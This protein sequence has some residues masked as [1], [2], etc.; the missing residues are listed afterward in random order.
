MHY[1]HRRSLLGIAATAAILLTGVGLGA[2][3]PAI[4]T[5]GEEAPA[6]ASAEPLAA[7]AQVNSTTTM[8]PV[9]VPGQFGSPF[10]ATATVELD[11]PSNLSGQIV[12]LW[13][14]GELAVS[15]PLLYIGSGK[16][17]GVLITQ[18]TP[19]AGDYK[20]VVKFPG[21]ASSD[22][23]MAG[24]LSSESAPFEFTVAPRPSTTTVT[25]AP[26]AEN[27]FAPIDV[28]ASVSAP[29]F[30][31]TGSAALMVDDLE[32]ATAPLQ[33]SPQPFADSPVEF[34]GVRL[35][36]TGGTLWVKYL[37]SDD[38][39]F[40]PSASAR[41]AIVIHPIDTSVDVAL[42][43]AQ[44]RADATS[45]LE[46]TVT[47]ETLRSSQDPVGGV[48]V[49]V[50]GDVIVTMAQAQDEDPRA[51]NGVARFSIPLAGAELGLGTHDIIVNFLPEPGFKASSSETAPLTVVG[52]PTVLTTV[53]S[54]VTGTPAHPPVVSVQATVGAGNDAA[55][56]ANAAGLQAPVQ[57]DSP[58]SNAAVAG[59][60][61]AFV[62]TESLG[63]AVPLVDGTAD[64]QLAGL[65]VGSHEVELQ[66]TP[67]GDSNALGASTSVTAVVSAD[68]TPAPQPVTP[69]HTTK[70]ALAKT[71]AADGQASLLLG[72]AAALIIG[73]GIAFSAPLRRG[74]QR[75]V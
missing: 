24:A 41:G 58:A 38:G 46:I 21:F 8:N 9:L 10:L 13:L 68:A 29:G 3:S 17:S 67:V 69:E 66:F 18:N 74:R 62:G 53:A 32:I 30:A 31:I 26:T 39:N 51:G 71:G 19:S 36:G 55:A 64:V 70:S 44:V 56:P 73:A 33:A 25:S 27:A 1:S 45:S 40:A 7:P 63:D 4:A 75:Q 57:A 50:D 5:S 23:G 12:E 54:T 52:I 28:S 49:L 47:N 20:A 11:G 14:N 6:S 43:S 65:A 2:S 61:E 72:A 48:E 60:L 59:Y 35:P 16:F 42:S 15:S 34:S 22:P 37:G